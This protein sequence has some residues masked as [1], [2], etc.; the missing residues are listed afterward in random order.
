MFKEERRK[1]QSL[2]DQLHTYW[3]ICLLAGLAFVGVNFLITYGIGI[4]T[5]KSQIMEYHVGFTNQDGI[6]L[7]TELGFIQR[8][9]EK[10]GSTM[11]TVLKLVLEGNK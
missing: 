4:P 1:K 8:D 9:L 5:A 11:D 3:L 2:K 7:K 10:L 6:I